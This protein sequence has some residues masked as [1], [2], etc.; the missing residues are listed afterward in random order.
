MLTVAFRSLVVALVSILLNLLSVGAAYGL[1]TLVFLDGVGDGL[2][3]FQHVHTID[4]WVPL[5]LFSVLFGALDGLPGVPDEPDQGALRP[6]GSTRDAVATASRR[7]R[8][9]SP[10]P[11]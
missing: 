11:R 8:G 2:F 6:G 4:A 1:L 10:A 7:P 5:F 3:G 9:S